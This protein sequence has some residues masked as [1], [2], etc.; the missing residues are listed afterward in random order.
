MSEHDLFGETW[1]AVYLETLRESAT[2]AT[3]A[4][5]WQGSIVLEIPADELPDDEPRAVFLDLHRG[6]CRDARPA[7]EEDR[8]SAAYVLAADLPT[9]RKVL[10]GDLDP[11]LGIMTG[12]LR[13]ARGSL[14]QLTP[15]VTAAK[16][17]VACARRVPTRFPD[18]SEA[19]S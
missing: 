10:A 14:A 18:Q 1:S 8:E 16:E 15:Y 13:L 19:A 11:L 6:A 9:W 4:A 5:N 17:L 2:Y 3:A 12:K 7:S